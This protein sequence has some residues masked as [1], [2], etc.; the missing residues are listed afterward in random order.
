MRASEEETTNG[1][2]AG[3]TKR[4]FRLKAAF[5]HVDCEHFGFL[6]GG[7]GA[8]VLKEEKFSEGRLEIEAPLDMELLKLS[9]H[10]SN[11]RLWE[12]PDWRVDALRLSHACLAYI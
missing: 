10:F 6:Y 9:Y 5:E 11:L 12:S 4:D 3:G 2:W 1:L 7:S 8:D